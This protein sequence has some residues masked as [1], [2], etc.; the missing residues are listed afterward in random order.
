[1]PKYLRRSFRFNQATIDAA[2][3]AS[4]ETEKLTSLVIEWKD[5]GTV[6]LTI[7]ITPDK[8]VWY[9]RRKETTIQLGDVRALPLDEARYIAHQVR[10]AAQKGKNLRDVVT[11]LMNHYGDFP[12]HATEEVIAAFIKRTSTRVEHGIADLQRTRKLPPRPEAPFWTWRQLTQNFLRYKKTRLK[13]GYGDEYARYLEL[14][15][16]DQIADKMVRDLKLRDLERVRDDIAIAFA[17]STAS[18][19]VTQGKAMLSWAWKYK[20]SASGLDDCEHEWWQR[21]SFEYRPKERTRTPTIQE[22]ARTL[23]V[24]EKFTHLAHGEH[25]TYPGT[26]GALWGVCLTAQR[27]GA[28]LTLRADRLFEPPKTERGLRHWKIANWT[29]DEMKGGRDGGRPHSLPLPPEA[30]EILTAYHKRSGGTSKWMFSGRD[31]QKHITQSALNLL[32]YRLQGRVY[33][34]T[35]KRKAPRKGKPGPKPRPR[36]ERPN[37]F[38]LYGIEAWSP[39]DC[40]RTLTTFLDDRRLG[41]AATAILG[42]KTSNTKT[43]ERE[44]LA[45]V[46]EQHYNRSQKL[47]LKADGMALWV[48]TLLAAYRKELKAFRDLTNDKVA[49]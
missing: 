42:H 16:F 36:K 21:W 30:L 37:L 5:R 7:R 24:A 43:D 6:G 12:R 34:H 32:L 38:E 33:D 29:A 26:L 39:H 18:R 35:V 22:I 8:P 11:L 47:A 10:L 15:Q 45:R 23:V 40:R 9:L 49:A 20:A 1:M 27:T 14:R 28:F 44:K 41:G 2:V 48:K 25:E 46:T 4:R 17:D 31:P 3:A 19:A 13:S